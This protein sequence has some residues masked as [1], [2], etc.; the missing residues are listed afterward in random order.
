MNNNK[1]HNYMQHIKNIQISERKDQL[2]PTTSN[3]DVETRWLLSMLN[4]NNDAGV[5]LQIGL[6]AGV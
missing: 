4:S 3:L 1:S 5:I 6:N 2:I